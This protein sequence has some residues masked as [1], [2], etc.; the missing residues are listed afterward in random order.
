MKRILRS[1]LLKFAEI[2]ST[3]K[4]VDIK[5]GRE[6]MIRAL[7]SSNKAYRIR[8][9]I[10]RLWSHRPGRY[11]YVDSDWSERYLQPS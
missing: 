6:R 10:E 11:I 9:S 8:E 7:G 2:S 5:S 1:K 3:L 4:Y